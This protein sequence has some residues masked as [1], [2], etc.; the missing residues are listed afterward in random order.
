MRSRVLNRQYTDSVG[1][2][3][4]KFGLYHKVRLPTAGRSMIF[5][6]SAAEL[7]VGA[8]ARDVYRLNLDQGRFRPAV[9]SC[10]DVLLHSASNRSAC[11]GPTRNFCAAQRSAQRAG[12]PHCAFCAKLARAK[13]HT[14]ARMVQKRVPD[15]C[16]PSTP[17]WTLSTFVRKIRSSHCTQLR[18]AYFLPTLHRGT[19]LPMHRHGTGPATPARTDAVSASLLLQAHRPLC[20][21]HRLCFVL[22]SYRR[23]GGAATVSAGRT[24]NSACSIRATLR[25]PQSA[26]P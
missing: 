18:R 16:S 7:L 15:S 14:G 24:A 10:V 1:Q 4:A 20:L 17:T 23:G 21:R 19:F 2:L 22:C 12:W 3:H 8:S 9:P 25:A 26:T 11:A 13:G 6:A 5:D